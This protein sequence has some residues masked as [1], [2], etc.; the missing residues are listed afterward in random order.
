MAMS[1]LFGCFFCSGF[2]L[3]KKKKKKLWV[4]GVLCFFLKF[5]GLLGFSVFLKFFGF[6][7][8]FFCFFILGGGKVLGFAQ[9][10]LS[11]LFLEK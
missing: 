5:F 10:V 6:L 7:G 9:N 11:K 4:F 8:L 1:L 3:F 2:W